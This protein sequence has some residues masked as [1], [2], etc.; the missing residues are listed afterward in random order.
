VSTD[1]A[2]SIADA[3]QQPVGDEDTPVNGYPG[4]SARQMDATA[5]FSVFRDSYQSRI[6]DLFAGITGSN[7]DLAADRQ[8]LR[9]LLSL[10]PP[11]IDELYALVILGGA[12]DT[13]RYARVIVDPAPTGHLLRL[14]DMP[15]LALAWSHQLMRLMLE[16]KAIAP[17]GDSAQELLDFARR[18]RTLD[19]RL[20]DR[21]QSAMILAALDEPLVRA[22]TERLAG[23]V[24]A[25]SIPLE[26]IVWNQSTTATAPLPDAAGVPQFFAPTFSPPPVG[27]G[28]IREWARHWNTLLA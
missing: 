21:S 20:H 9:D 5:A 2:P 26:A 19:A 17:L 7:M 24:R 1:P 3:L 23:A 25:R 22:E 12:L 16:Y 27:T 18:T 13:G 4:L 10:A 15:A 6:D 11:G 28:E 8:I 14:L